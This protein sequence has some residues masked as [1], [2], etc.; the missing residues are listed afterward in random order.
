[1][2]GTTRPGPPPYNL[3]TGGWLGREY[4][5][6]PTGGQPRNED[7]TA[8]VAEA[9]E[10]EFN[11]QALGLPAGMDVARLVGRRSLRERLDDGL[12]ALEAARGG[13]A[14]AEQYREA[15]G[16]LTSPAVR[17]AFALEREPAALR[18]RYGRT[19]IG[20]RC[21]LAR[22]LVEAGARFVLVDYGYDP[23]FGKPW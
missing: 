21:L 4:A 13:D 2:P 23:E 18:D 9:V 14:L 22:R 7:F 16:M 10:E 15:F 5:P 1:M 12:R 6:F 11:Q 8:R 19:K 3:F 17:S 20:Q